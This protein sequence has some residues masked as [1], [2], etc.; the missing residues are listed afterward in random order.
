MKAS[1]GIY[2][3]G[4]DTDVGKTVVSA[5]LMHMM[6]SNGYNACYFK[7]VSSGGTENCNGCVSPYLHEM[8]E[9]KEKGPIASI[10]N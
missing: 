3:I 8:K 4:T 6:L 9:A 10:Y 2:I 1:K 5:G 7:P